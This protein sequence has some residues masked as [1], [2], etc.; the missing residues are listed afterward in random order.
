MSSRSKQQGSGCLQQRP[1]KCCFIGLRLY[2]CGSLIYLSGKYLP[3]KMNTISEQFQCFL[4]MYISLS[5]A[6]GFPSPKKLAKQT[7]SR[8]HQ[9]NCQTSTNLTSDNPGAWSVSWFHGAEPN[10]WSQLTSFLSFSLFFFRES[11]HNIFP[12]HTAKT[13]LHILHAYPPPLT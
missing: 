11:W 3:W 12:L 2:V 8:Y 10:L 9:W 7:I 13:N 1:E 6:L 4:Y 5:L